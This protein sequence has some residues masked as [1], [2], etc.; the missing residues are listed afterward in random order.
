[1]RAVFDDKPIEI[2]IPDLEYAKIY[3]KRGGNLTIVVPE[4]KFEK[5]AEFTQKNLN[6][7]K[8]EIVCEKE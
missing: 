7:I 4:E 1:M 5:I 8:I 3:L 2:T 6:E